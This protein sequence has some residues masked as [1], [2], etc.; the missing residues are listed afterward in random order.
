MKCRLEKLWIKG[1]PEDGSNGELTTPLDHESSA[2]SS[3]S[4]GDT[5]I[6]RDNGDSNV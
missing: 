4:L 2:A 5:H 3:V 1:G 6:W